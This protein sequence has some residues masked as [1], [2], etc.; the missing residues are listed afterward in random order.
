[1]YGSA[2]MDIFFF[3]SLPECVCMCKTARAHIC[4]S[5]CFRLCEPSTQPSVTKGPPCSRANHLLPTASRILAPLS[6]NGP[7]RQT[8]IHTPRMTTS[9]SCS[10]R[11]ARTHTYTHTTQ[12]HRRSPWKLLRPFPSVGRI[13]LSSQ[14]QVVA[15]LVVQSHF[16]QFLPSAA[17]SDWRANRVKFAPLHVKY[18]KVITF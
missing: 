16:D 13:K 8:H 18:N 7:A 4:V 5:G 6:N 15:C 3:P 11:Q 1:M 2:C 17:L 10:Y 14:I 12:S 9:A